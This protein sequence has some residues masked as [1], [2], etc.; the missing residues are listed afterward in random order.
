MSEVD[1]KAE[2]KKTAIV[3]K[4][5]ELAQ[6]YILIQTEQDVRDIGQ[7]L[8]GTKY[9]ATQEAGVRPSPPH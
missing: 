7:A 8:I 4:I 3:E 1:Q 9:R 2:E 5:L 6:E